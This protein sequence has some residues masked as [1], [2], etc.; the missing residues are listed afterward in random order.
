MQPIVS[1]RIKS[2]TC[3]KCGNPDVASMAELLDLVS[4]Q[5]G[6]F[7]SDMVE[8]LAPPQR[9]RRPLSKRHRTGIRNSL[10]FGLFW[11]GL[12][13][14]ACYALSGALPS[15]AFTGTAFA[16]AV[17]IGLI[18]WRSEAKLA[19]KEDKFL[20]DAHWER[21]RA[22]LERRRVWSRLR[23]CSKCALVIDPVT[24]QTASIYNVHELAN[25][26]VKEVILR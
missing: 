12:I 5:S 2:A 24:L 7:S 10:A 8:W 9:P 4:K 18:N 14:A 16:V 25:S 19:A 26:K 21:Y 6:Q 20:L 17:C 13:T 11:I 1:D 3:P 22:Y 15:L 23:Y